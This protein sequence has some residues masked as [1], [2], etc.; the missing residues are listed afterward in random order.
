MDHI[1]T[2]IYINQVSNNDMLELYLW[3]DFYK[4]ASKFKHKLY[5]SS[6]SAHPTE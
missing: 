2:V 3:Y 1:R 6:G 4:I 5:I